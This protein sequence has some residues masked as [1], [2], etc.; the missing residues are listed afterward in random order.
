MLSAIYRKSEAHIVTN[1]VPFDVFR[2]L[3]V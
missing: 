3:V 2:T 1:L